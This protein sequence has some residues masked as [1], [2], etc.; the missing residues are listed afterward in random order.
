MYFFQF[1]SI[2]FNSIQ[3]KILYYSG[4]HNNI[5]NVQ[6]CALKQAFEST[7]LGN[8]SIIQCVPE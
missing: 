5:I 2:Q 6:I 4:E 3:F 8:N 7:Q 1:N